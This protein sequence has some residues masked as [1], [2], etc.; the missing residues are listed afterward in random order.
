MRRRI[1]VTGSS[2]TLVPMPRL[3]VS[4][5]TGGLRSERCRPAAPLGECERESHAHREPAAQQ[6]TF[7]PAH[8]LHPGR[9]PAMGGAAGLTQGPGLLAR[10]RT[11]FGALRSLS[12]IPIS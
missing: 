7:A 2:T 4:T 1:I 11:R 5:S 10:D 3:I 9:Q 6:A 8:R 12:L